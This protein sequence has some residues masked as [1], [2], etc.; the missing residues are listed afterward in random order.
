MMPALTHFGPLS[1]LP[2]RSSG[3]SRALRR[4]PARTRS[5]MRRGARGITAMLAVVALIAALLAP[6]ASAQTSAIGTVVVANGW[7]S[8]DSAV[9]S[10]LAAL[11]S[12]S[13]TDAVALYA[14][15]KELT[16][17]TANFIK[18]HK[19]SEVILIGGTAAL[20]AGVEAEAVALVGRSS[21]RRIEG[22]DRFDT[23]AK[24][25]PSNA[26]TFI[27]ANGYSAADTGVAAALAATKA[28]AAVLLATADS[29]TN[30]TERIIRSQ[31]PAAIEFVGG[32]AVLAGP[33]EERVRE[34]A[35]QVSSVPR[36]SGASRTETAAAAVPSGSSTFV[37]ANGWSPADMGVAAAYAAITDGAAVLY[38]ERNAVATA[39]VS[40]IRALAP[41]EIVLVGGNAALDFSLHRRIHDLAS[42]AAIRRI[43]GS[44]RIDTAVRAASRTLTRVSTVRPTP[45]TA[46]TV[47]ARVAG[48]AVSWSAPRGATSDVD[49]GITGYDVRFQACDTTPRT[50]ETN[51][52]WS[53][54]ATH[55]QSGT[56]TTA[57]LT[58]LT[59]G[60]KYQVEVRARNGFGDSTWSQRRSGTPSADAA[61]PT[62]LTVVA[63]DR[64]LS[65]R[66]TAPPPS[67][68]PVT[69]YEVQS[70]ACTATD[71]T[72]ATSQNWGNWTSR[73]HSGIATATAITG[74]VNGTKYEVRVRARTG[75]SADL[76]PWSQPA[77]G[78]PVAQTAKPSVP[79]GVMVEAA[80]QLLKVSWS[81]SIPPKDGTVSGYEV[82]Y[83]RCPSGSCGSWQPHDHSGTGTTTTISGLNNGVEY[84]VQVRAASSKGDSGWSP[85]T[86][87]TPAQ[88]PGFE[89]PPALTAGNRQILVQWNEPA[90]S[91]SPVRDYDV[92]YRVCTATDSDTSD[93]TCEP[94]G[95]ATW[96]RWRP[97]S[98]SGTA[99]LAT[100]TGLTNGTA[101][102]VQVRASN[103]NGAGPW[104]EA[105]KATPISV[106]ARP[107]NPMVEPGNQGFVVTWT[108]PSDN[109]S[110]ITRYDVEYCT[111][112][113]VSG[114]SDWQDA[115]HSD[116]D[117][118][119]DFTGTAGI[120]NGTPYKVRVRAAN[121]QGDGQWL[122]FGT[123]RPNLLPDAPAAPTLEA[124]DGEIVVVWSLPGTNGT[125]II[126]YD[127]Q[128]RACTA[129]PRDCT[130]NPR[131]ERW[132]TKPH[133]DTSTLEATVK[134]LT[135]ATKYEVRVRARISP[136]S[137]GVGPPSE[138]SPETPRGKPAM[139]ST[140]KVT[141]G[142][143]ELTLT[144]TPP[145]DSGSPIRGYTIQRCESTANCTIGS[146]WVDASL[147][148]DQQEA[149]LAPDERT[150]TVTH[151]L[152]GLTNGTTYRV[153]VRA[154]NDVGGEGLGLGPWS[155]TVSGTP[156]VR[157]DEPANVSMNVDNGQVGLLW[158]A[159]NNKGVQLTGYDI[160]YR[161]CEATDSDDTVLTCDADTEQPW[162]DWK[163]HAHSGVG[164]TATI[165]GL[166][167]GTAYQV[168]VRARNANGPGPWSAEPHATGTPLAAPSP[169]TGLI[170]EAAHQRLSVSW[171]QSV[172]NGATI[173][174]YVMQH[175]ACTAKPT[176]CASNAKWSDWEPAD[177]DTSD[178]TT[179]ARPIPPSGGTDLVN[180]TKY[181]VR[182]KATSASSGSS[183]WSQTESATPAAVPDA[184]TLGTP[185]A[186]DRQISIGWNRGE[187][188]GAAITDYDVEYRA[189]IATDSDATDLT[190]APAA[191]ATWGNWV[192]HGHSGASESTII[193]RLTN[194]TA[195][196]VRVRASNAN[197]T[198]PWSTTTAESTPIGA[199][200]APTTPIVAVGDR[201]LTVDWIV[202]RSNGSKITGYDVWYRPCIS[203]PDQYKVQSCAANPDWGDETAWEKRDT[204]DTPTRLDITGLTNGIAYQVQV[205]A[206]DTNRSPNREG[207]W[208]SPVVAMPIG[209]PSWP[210]K[211]EVASGNG[212]LFVTW[213]APN[214]N[215]STVTGYKIRY[216]DTT[217]A[218]KD[219]FSDYDDWEP[220]TGI[221]ATI[222]AT[223]RYYSISG[224]DNSHAYD[225]EMLT[226]SRSKGDSD[227][228]AAERTTAGGPSQPSRPGLTAR[229]GEISVSWNAPTSRGH[230]AI[231]SYDV[232][233]RACTAT[234]SDMSV[235][236]C[237][238][239]PTWGDWVVGDVSIM[240]RTATISNLV[241]G[242]R[243]EVRVRANN[244]QGAGRWSKADGTTPTS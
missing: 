219:C 207:P 237:A 241:S 230:T 203:T 13:R 156:S 145:A 228:R 81:P 166:T 164:I 239:N 194:G 90:D 60:T 201:V 125:T 122:L 109:G 231:T 135:N 74:L 78:T 210:A 92:Q 222:G 244:G 37:I 195:Y 191:K 18:D 196:Q 213:S 243:Y 97:H 146:N 52:R 25:V 229:S 172:S 98:H 238:S 138:A 89:R 83:R 190:C 23:A 126:G 235:L 50:C 193:T 99:Q 56:D 178:D 114:S 104:S 142:D 87:A 148:E 217:D 140:P 141:A 44:D 24:A 181:Q 113:C 35:P 168:R 120:V 234:N 4:R 59:N 58:N 100:I 9:A 105:N 27:V 134:N 133:S 151:T 66:W 28:D 106:P 167:N 200:A 68:S 57:V 80:N 153:R 45:P 130:S 159:A 165:T 47:S 226:T 14:N 187:V 119:L 26:A 10:A 147:S 155:S 206:K 205:R 77:S 170:V 232:E 173:T 152:I 185:V 215:G 183:G 86:K 69:G 197:G 54:W 211:I 176:D 111:G 180:G 67:G 33:L 208:S 91:G 202:P 70:R 209:R 42:S 29:L 49:L 8:A 84:E 53:Q 117:T 6:A 137:G 17:R 2:R 143:G 157:P 41:S 129:T 73:S 30:A 65:L 96:D 16:T 186:D 161:A 40:R 108:A 43:S 102:E 236:T 85:S 48:L 75:A 36:H 214:S 107:R 61:R 5:A 123:A 240:G 64:R 116:T 128:Y 7:S 160:E 204:G 63:A 11:K 46:V 216:C 1:G 179:T 127:I 218:A 149:L 51:P 3:G 223:S 150:G 124:G 175:R 39:V 136:N 115:G 182:V 71:R 221:G 95:K 212:N 31:R 21:V 224:L 171:T 118:R 139:P 192:T 169:P 82:Q 38:T 242:T 15:T 79:S 177:I 72:C 174:G 199:P 233:H 184:P 110:E 227:W 220:R 158:D 112:D 154:V 34:L 93:L 189:C 225:V 132:R 76:G 94:D 55:S 163:T 103:S 62:G 198:G 144:W 32:T 19:P 20:S 121:G 22:R 162:G 12:N 101:Y 131:W 88:L 188:H